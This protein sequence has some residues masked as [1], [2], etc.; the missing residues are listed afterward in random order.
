MTSK[1]D[2]KDLEILREIQKDCKQSSKRMSKKLRTPI[3]TI[4]SKIKRM[5][6]LGIINGYN[7]VVSGKK[8]GKG[9]TAFVL[10]SF[11]KERDLSQKGMSKEIAKLKQIQEVHI[12]TGDWDLIVKVKEKDVESLGNFVTES[13]RAIK[14][15]DKTLSLIVYHTEKE[16]QEIMI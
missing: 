6:E 15:V 7:A 2:K 9:V 5:E 1:L 11:H 16:T 8:L 4:Y 12:I 14:G 13:L 3:T 10:V